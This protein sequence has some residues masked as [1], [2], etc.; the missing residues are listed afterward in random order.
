MSH[1]AVLL[2]RD[3]TLVETR[4]YPSEPDELVIYDGLAAELAR[5][6]GAGFRLALIT[7]QSGLAHGY[8]DLVQLDRM[9][10]FL[11][12]ELRHEGVVIDAVYYCPHH[13]EGKV[14]ELA[15]SCECRKPKPGMLLK[16]AADLDLDLARS[17]FIGDIL[18]DVEAGNRAGCRTVLI[19]LGTE[20]EP[21]HPIRQPTYIARDSVHALRIVQ[22]AVGLLNDVELGYRPTRWTSELSL[23]EAMKP[24]SNR[25]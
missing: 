10:H 5:V 25:L 7:N 23:S 22:A 18:D 24:A 21:E 8:F 12:A 20:H 16:A 6:T 14:Q 9:H 17:W 13:P 19:D 4:H 15:I 2:D 11:S 3:G 1:C